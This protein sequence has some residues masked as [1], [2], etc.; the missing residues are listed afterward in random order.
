MEKEEYFYCEKCNIIPLVHLIAQGS[1]IK[2]FV[3]CKCE[4]K[5]IS[6][7]LFKKTFY[8]KEKKENISSMKEEELNNNI[9]IEEITKQYKD[10]KEEINKYNLEIKNN[11]IS[12]YHT[13]IKEIEKLY[14]DNKNMNDNL[15]LFMN[16]LISNY[17]KDNKNYSNIN[18]ILINTNLNK[19]Y[20]KKLSNYKFENLN[21]MTFISYEREAKNYFI[22]QHIISPDISE[23][24]TIKYLSGH[25]DSINCFVEINDN[26]K[27]LG[28]SCSRDSYIILYDLAEMKQII[29]FVGHEKGVN[30]IIKSSTNNL[31]SCGDDS[32]IK[33]WPIVN[34]DNYKEISIKNIF[35]I[36]TSEPIKKIIDLGD[37]R[38][39][40]GSN[41][42]IYIYEND[43]S[44]LNLVKELKKDKINDIILFEN[45]GEKLI[46]G[47]TGTEVFVVDLNGLRV[48]NEIKCEGP[49]WQN[50]LVQINNED[51]IYGN[52]KELY[53]INIKKGKIKLSKA[54][55]GYINCIFKLKD[56][57]I[58]RGER[59]GIRRYK[60]D[61]LDELPPLIEPF[62]DYDDNHSAEHLNYL[63]ELSDGN[64]VLCYR[65]SSIKLCKLKTG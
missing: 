45:D 49:Y 8:H 65:N 39:I 18:N 43:N 64:I 27:K 9:N 46:V 51:V 58:I 6:Y 48:L 37:N 61:T 36:K 17:E 62:D 42:G 1:N 28:V 20:K 12:H 10:L 50:N 55:S 31:I 14:E 29:K 41:K 54:T 35:E 23:L 44:K 59:D 52:N 53:V 33:I 13:K 56:G 60:G 4:K 3:V 26:N 38:I 63:Y 30:Y 57:S 7:D 21:D 2:V 40:A 16:G 15:E 19:Y 11:I 22:N 32:S 25:D 24:K 47:Y 34:Q 5:L